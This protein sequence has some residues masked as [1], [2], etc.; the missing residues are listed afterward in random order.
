MD[1]WYRLSVRLHYLIKGTVIY[2]ESWLSVFLRNNH[3]RKIPCR[4]IPF[5]YSLFENLFKF[6]SHHL[7]LSSRQSTATRI[8]RKLI[9]RLKLVLQLNFFRT[10]FKNIVRVNLELFQQPGT[11]S[12][13]EIFQ[14]TNIIFAA[15]LPGTIWLFLQ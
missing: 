9:F 14:V 15:Y 10:D 11:L 12:L 1:L 4:T 6:P 7:I 5:T 8:D 2:E 3:Y 13:W